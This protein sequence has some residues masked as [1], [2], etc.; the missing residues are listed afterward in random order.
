[1]PEGTKGEFELRLNYDVKPFE[2]T[3]K[4]TKIELK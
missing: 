4:T 1:V 2:L 3:T